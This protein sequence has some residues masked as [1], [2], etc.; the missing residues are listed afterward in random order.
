MS[1]TVINLIGIKALTK[2]N[3]DTWRMQI[4]TLMIK[5]DFR[6]TLP[7]MQGDLY[8]LEMPMIVKR[9]HTRRIWLSNDRKVKSDLILSIHPTELS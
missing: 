2:D 9:K 4:E 5:I 1:G 7:E 3:Y 6:I 8:W